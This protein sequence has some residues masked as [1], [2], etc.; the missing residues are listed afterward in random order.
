MR[1]QPCK[2]GVRMGVQFRWKSYREVKVEFN[3]RRDM[4]EFRSVDAMKHDS[5]R[6]YTTPETIA[7][8]RANI[9]FIFEGRNSVEPIMNAERAREQAKTRSL[10]NDSQRR[11]I[12]EVLNSSDR[13]HGLQ[14]LAGTGKTTTLQ[15]VREGAESRGYVVEGFA[16]TSKAAG[17]LREAGIDATTLQ[18]FLARRQSH[19]IAG[20]VNRHLYMLDESSLASFS[21]KDFIC[22]VPPTISTSPACTSSMS[23]L[24]RCGTTTCDC[25]AL[26]KPSNSRPHTPR[27][28]NSVS[29]KDIALTVVS[30]ETIIIS[31][32][33][34]D[35]LKGDKSALENHLGYRLR[36][37]SNAVSSEF[38]HALQ[39]RQ[40]SVAEWVLLRMVSER[41]QTT[42]GELAEIVGMTRG[43][44]SKVVDKLEAKLWLRVSTA[45][46]D[47]RVRLLSLTRG[48]RRN[49]PILAKIADENDA[50]F[51]SCLNADEKQ[52]FQR[53]LDKLAEQNNIHDVPT[54]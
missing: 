3:L 32:E 44:V 48:G 21:R 23:D 8:E 16:P 31:M 51:F 46:S 49:L 18:S 42:P 19:P 45:D 7:S 10:L 24:P 12:E 41:T 14:G 47:N 50:R 4:G 36:R 20:I 53:L 34:I 6:N 9:R 22:F 15:S 33:T 2:S 27:D 54:S 5:G 1:G 17:Q 38:A 13:V 40:T 26:P 11:V 30:M 29:R 39:V 35:G 52:T 37:I 25:R 43:A 28:K